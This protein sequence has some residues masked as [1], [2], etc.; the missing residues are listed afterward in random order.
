MKPKNPARR[1]FLYAALASL[2][3]A[4]LL[5]GAIAYFQTGSAPARPDAPFMRGALSR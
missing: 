3:M 2:A 1:S 5:V 4:A